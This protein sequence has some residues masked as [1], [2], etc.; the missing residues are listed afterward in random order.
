MRAALRLGLATA[1]AVLAVA[2]W[3]LAAAK[4]AGAFWLAGLLLT[5]AALGL[6]CLWRLARF[7]T[8]VSRYG[9]HAGCWELALS[10][11]KAAVVDTWV[12]PARRWRRWF[13]ASEVWLELAT[14]KGKRELAIPCGQPQE[15]VAALRSEPSP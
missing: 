15:L 9:V 4:V 14:P 8:L 3:W 7:Q 12:R 1:T 11:P 5:L 2:G 10:F 13:A 6:F